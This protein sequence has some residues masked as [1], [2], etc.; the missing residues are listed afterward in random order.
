MTKIFWRGGAACVAGLMLAMAAPAAAQSP[1]P[2]LASAVAAYEA[3]AL[4]LEDPGSV[5]AQWTLPDVTPAAVAARQA[6]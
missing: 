5:G 4:P 3:I 2:H 6:G 1:R